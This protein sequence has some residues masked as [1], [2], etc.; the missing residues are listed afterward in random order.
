MVDQQLEA[1]APAVRGPPDRAEDCT[2]ACPSA[3]RHENFPI[4]F[5]PSEDIHLTLL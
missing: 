2:R 5:V 1:K 4:G 3:R